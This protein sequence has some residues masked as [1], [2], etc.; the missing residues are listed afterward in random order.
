M[1]LPDHDIVFTPDPELKEHWLDG[2]A[3]SSGSGRAVRA[4]ALAGIL[5]AEFF[6]LLALTTVFM[7]AAGRE[8]E[9]S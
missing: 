7:C 5:G 9:G 6:V 4:L 8:A 1:N 2:W 3:A